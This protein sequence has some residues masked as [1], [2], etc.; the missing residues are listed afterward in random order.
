MS[1]VK[2]NTDIIQRWHRF[3][4]EKESRQEHL[5]SN[6]LYLLIYLE[7]ALLIFLNIYRTIRTIECQMDHYQTTFNHF[8]TFI[9]L[10]S[11]VY[12]TIIEA[13]RI[14]NKRLSDHY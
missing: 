13:H 10:P 7:I 2:Y 1:F 8:G 6:L 9:E 11:N 12:R 14:F 4:H 3:L 5:L